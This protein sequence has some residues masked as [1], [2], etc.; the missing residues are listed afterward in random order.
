MKKSLWTE[1]ARGLCRCCHEVS[2]LVKGLLTRG[3]AVGRRSGVHQGIGLAGGSGSRS[4]YQS[5]RLW[6]VDGLWAL[7]VAPI[8]SLF[9]QGIAG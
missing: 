2:V 6:T 1:C 8:L 7:V 5:P 9:L 3:A 4:W